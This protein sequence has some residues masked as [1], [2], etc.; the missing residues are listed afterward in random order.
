MAWLVE[1]AIENFL[2]KIVEQAINMFLTFLAAINGMA[3]DVLSMDVV[4]Q[5]IGYSQAL[6]GTILVTKIAYEA[7]TTYVLRQNG[8]PDAD[9]GGLLIRSIL[10]AAF[11]GGMPWLVPWLYKFGTTVANDVA[12]LPGVNY[13]SAS[14]PIESLLSATI[15]SGSSIFFIFLAVIFAVIVFIIILIQTFI[16]AAELAIAA[17]VG[18]F[19]ALGLTNSS[20]QAFSSWFKEM[21]ALALTQA[22]QLFMIKVSFFAL[23]TFQVDGGKHATFQVDGGNPL[24]RLFLFCGFLW[25]TYKSPSI[26]KSYIHSTGVGKAVGGAAQSVGTMMM[27]RK[28]FT[29]GL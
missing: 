4:K 14:T 13:D 25:V 10:S 5:G 19:M 6:A 11:I 2:Q 27:M 23:A 1:Q 7:W 12:K 9:P 26:L 8:D 20:S 3:S 15:S 22:V 17:V 21:L 28:M 29:R 24:F 16:R 18:S